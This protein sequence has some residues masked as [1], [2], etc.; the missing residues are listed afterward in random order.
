MISDK[1][2][3]YYIGASD[4]Q[5]VVGNWTTKTFGK[6]YMSKLGFG[7][8]EFTSNAMKAGTSYEHKILESL[9]VPFLEMDKQLIVGRL[10]VNLDGSTDDTIYEVKTHKAEKV[11]KPTKAYRDQVN[12]QMYATGI[13]NAYIIAYALEEVDY[14]NYYR[15]IEQSRLSW[16]KISYDA[17]FIEHIYLPR[18]RYLSHC[19]DGGIFPKEEG[20]SKWNS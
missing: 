8:M 2:R 9:A 7:S 1:D 18:L 14:D 5:S 17:D 20:F 16:H 19:L 4:T 13:K 15:D 3:S 11:F 10:R 12:V 6:W